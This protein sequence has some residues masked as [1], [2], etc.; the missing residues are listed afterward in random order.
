MKDIFHRQQLAFSKSPM[1]TIY[2]RELQ[3]SKLRA[4][5][6]EYKDAIANAI[7]ADFTAR[8]IDETMMVEILPCIKNIDYTL[9]KL[10]R[11]M[12]PVRRNVAYYFLPASAQ[13]IYQPVG[14]VGLVVPFNYPVSQAALPLISALATG[15]RVMIKMSEYTPLT[16]AVF[17]TMLSE[18]FEEDHVAVITGDAEIGAAFSRL[19]FDHLLFTGSTEVGKKI[20]HAAADNL[21]PVTLELGGK[22]PA[23]IAD[24]IPLEDII[25]RLCYAKALNAGQTCVAPDYVLLPR[26]KMG[27]FI[28]LYLNAFRKMYPT[29]AG[30]K[31]Y[32]SLHNAKSHARMTEFLQDA[33]AK[34]ARIFKSSDELVSDGTFRMAMHL[35]TNVTDEMKVMQEEI[36]GPIFPIVPYDNIEEAL[37]YVRQRPRPLGLYLFSYDHALQEHV[38]YHTHAGTMCINEALF[39]VAVDDLPFGGIGPSGMGHYHGHEGFLNMSKAKAIF[40]KG[41][42]TSMRL[43][44]PP[45]GGVI[46]KFLQKWLI[47]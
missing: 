1:P 39:Q 13:V 3:L 24:D 44:Y 30:N 40:K 8:S 21:T 46:Q 17:K 27:S 38:T 15:N 23:I 11:W 41:R 22:S 32:T 16:A 18:G 33:E 35:V 9:G 2:E 28:E 20:M 45:Y 4:L 5:L 10:K 19:P 47:R 25:D 14:V 43:V 36:F 29:L 31:D 37:T 34:G 42:F 26:G 12:K 6:I 7:S